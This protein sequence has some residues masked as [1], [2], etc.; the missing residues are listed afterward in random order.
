M[1]GLKRLQETRKEN[2]TLLEEVKKIVWIIRGKWREKKE[3]GLHKMKEIK[4]RENKIGKKKR[5]N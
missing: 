3:F 1:D 5:E 2:K 4:N